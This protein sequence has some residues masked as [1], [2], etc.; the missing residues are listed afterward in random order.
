VVIGGQNVTEFIL[1]YLSQKLQQCSVA[2]RFRHEAVLVAFYV[3][4]ER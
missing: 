4:F 3:N 2:Q 1:Q